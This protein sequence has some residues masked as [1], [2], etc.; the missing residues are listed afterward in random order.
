MTNPRKL[1]PLGPLAV[2]AILL[3]GA[4]ALA[5]RAA[6]AGER[7]RPGL[8]EVT[9]DV[10]GPG[11]AVPPSSQTQCMSQEDLDADPVPEMEKGVCRAT[12]I[13][14]AG[15]RVTWEVNCG[16]LGHGKG[17]LEYSSPTSYDGRMELELSGASLRAT[18][19]ARRTGDC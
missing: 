4:L 10:S 13:H 8:W 11:M 19:R 12:N 9:V 1:A 6:L 16:E 14:R 3:T 2:T 5:P 17:E 7:A 15:N 18:I